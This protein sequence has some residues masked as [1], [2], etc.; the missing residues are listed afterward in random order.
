MAFF[1]YALV[2]MVV[3]PWWAVAGANVIGAWGD[4]HATFYG[5][6]GGNETMREFN[7]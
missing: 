6:M 7:T 5:D 3:A 1:E 4:A 2:V